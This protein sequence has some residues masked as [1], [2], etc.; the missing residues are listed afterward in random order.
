MGD[1]S[2]T[3]LW[4]WRTDRALRSQDRQSGSSPET[5]GSIWNSSWSSALAQAG[6]W[7]CAETAGCQAS[8]DL[9]I[10]QE[11]KVQE[12]QSPRGVPR[13][14]ARAVKRALPPERSR[15]TAETADVLCS[16]G[17]AA[18]THPC[19]RPC[20]PQRGLGLELT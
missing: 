16:R 5:W 4:T 9:P 14:R 11:A 3:A 15:P 8:K 18:R 1:W 6:G 19:Q 10:K 13:I 17:D 12:C 2:W 20:L 7:G